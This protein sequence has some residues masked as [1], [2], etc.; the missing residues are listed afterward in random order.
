MNK[1][2]KVIKIN[3]TPS[4]HFDTI[5][6]TDHLENLLN[7][8]WIIER[9]TVIPCSVSAANYRGL[10]SIIYILSIDKV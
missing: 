8:G 6:N 3:P 5:S 4:Q 7:D 10:S 1:S 9:E 2:Y